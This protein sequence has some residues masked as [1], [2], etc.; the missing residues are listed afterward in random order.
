MNQD[1]VLLNL[2]LEGAYSTLELLNLLSGYAPPKE[3]TTWLKTKNNGFS[4]EKRLEVE[5]HLCS[6]L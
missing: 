1:T 4:I 2:T 6:L 5:Y 3:G